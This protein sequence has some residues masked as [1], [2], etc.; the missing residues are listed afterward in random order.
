MKRLVPA[1][2]IHRSVSIVLVSVCAL[3]GAAGCR[4]LVEPDAELRPPLE[5]SIDGRITERNAVPIGIFQVN[6]S[7]SAYA[8]A[9]P[10]VRSVAVSPSGV[11]SIPVPRDFDAQA[12]CIQTHWRRR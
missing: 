9:S 11:F 5:R 8:S 12:V 10:Y 3:A 6:L 7:N 4:S 2:T 1:A